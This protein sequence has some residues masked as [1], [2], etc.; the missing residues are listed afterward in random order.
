M[1]F[2]FVLCRV[3]NETRRKY[4][5]EIKKLRDCN[6][7]NTQPSRRRRSDKLAEVYINST[8]MSI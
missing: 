5:N 1:L 2:S 7:I 8:F 3:G 4:K 6:K